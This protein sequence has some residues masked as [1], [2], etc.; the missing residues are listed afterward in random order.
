M[1]VSSAYMM[2]EV[3]DQMKTSIGMTDDGSAKVFENTGN[4]IAKGVADGIK[5]SQSN[6]SSA[7]QNAIDN[8]VSNANFSGI[9]ARVN[10]LLGDQL[11]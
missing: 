5:A 4:S 1:R 10:R 6:I 2:D 7:L 3:Y 9:S 8:A 11:K